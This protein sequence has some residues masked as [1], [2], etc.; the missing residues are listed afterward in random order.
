MDKRPNVASLNF[1][2]AEP[3]EEQVNAIVES[4][5]P[6]KASDAQVIEPPD[7]GDEWYVNAIRQPIPKKGPKCP[8]CGFRGHTK[9]KCWKKH[10]HLRRPLIFRPGK[11]KAG[12]GPGDLTPKGARSSK[13]CSHCKM[14][15][16]LVDQCWKKHQHLKAEFEA[17]RAEKGTK[18]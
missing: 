6:R 15:G 14:T 17:K 12:T 3:V 18:S 5:A 16:H 9:D 2:G 7:D 10:P 1:M 8:F 13:Q 11:P 4:E